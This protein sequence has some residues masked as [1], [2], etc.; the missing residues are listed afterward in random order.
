MDGINVLEPKGPLFIAKVLETPTVDCNLDAVNS[1]DLVIRGSAFTMDLKVFF[2]PAIER[3][4]V[5]TIIALSPHKALLRLIPGKRWR[6]G[7]G[8]LVVTFVDT[9][10]GK[11]QLNGPHGV[12][13]ATVA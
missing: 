2:E 9:G 12:V 5:Y 3:G 10:A 7:T 13:V 11:V 8:S 4:V 6:E 1:D